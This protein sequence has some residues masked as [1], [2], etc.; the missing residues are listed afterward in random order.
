MP[1]ITFPRI[2]EKNMGAIKLLIVILLI[3]AIISST[4]VTTSDARINNRP[5]PTA[6]PRPTVTATPTP[7]PSPTQTP[8]LSSFGNTGVGSIF[9][10][11]DANAQSI[12]YF[13]CAS[14]GSVTDII[15]YIAGVSSG[16]AIAA[17]YAVNGG[18][19]GALL[20][21][22]NSVSLGTTFSWVDFKL[23]TPATVTSGTT[24]G[25][26]IMGNVAVNVMDVSGTGQR[27]HN[28]VSS[29]ASGFA[30]PFETVWGTD[31]SGAMSI[32]ATGT[33]SP[34]PTA[35]PTPSP[36]S[37]STPTI[38]PTPIPSS[39]PSP[40]PQASMM[41]YSDP[42]CTTAMSSIKWGT[43][44]IGGKTTQMVYV[45]NTGSGVSLALNMTTS[46]WTPTSANGP[47]T[48]TWNQEGTRLQPGQ[49]VAATLTLAVSSTIVD[50]TNFN[51][52]ISIFGTN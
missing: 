32:Y 17:I 7:T 34:T 27:D 37:V 43:L 8:T 19:A 50:V 14:A 33:S 29:Y 3:A 12:S 42:A 11:N 10:Q 39:T 44:A 49:S 13:T 38:T 30:N 41:I 18:S 2:T 26:A 24:Y 22:S 15:A 6:T 51:V 40:S 28:A 9:E 5:R 35:T 48:L 20:G 16:N 21:Q 23:A 45:K 4:L 36:T 47:I 52:Q 25:F 31:N 46:N 1:K